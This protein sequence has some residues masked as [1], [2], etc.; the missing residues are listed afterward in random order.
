MHNPELITYTDMVE[1]STEILLFMLT[2][3]TSDLSIN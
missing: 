1:N 2:F 3:E